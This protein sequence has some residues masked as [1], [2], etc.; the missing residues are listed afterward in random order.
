[1]SNAYL[2]PPALARRLGVKPA[3]ILAWIR[4]GEITAVNIGNGQSKPRWRISPESLADWERR[5][6]SQ[7]NVKAKPARRRATPASVIEFF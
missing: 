2:S 7:A 6:S 5:R 4:T 3:K 1:M